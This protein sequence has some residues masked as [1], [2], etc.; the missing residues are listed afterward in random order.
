VTNYL[1]GL[2]TLLQV[3]FTTTAD[4]LGRATGFIQRQRRLRAAAFAQT[5]VFRWMAKPT[6]TL[7]AL[8]RQLQLSPQALHQRLGPRAQS[9]LRALL[10]EALRAALKVPPQRLGL[11]D[12]FTAV[13][14]EDTT[15][16]ALPAALADEF[17][18]CGGGT[19]AGEGAAALKVLVRWDVRSGAVLALTV[20]AGR[21]SDQELAA[22][23]AD[24]P[25]GALHLADQGFFNSRRWQAFSPRQFWISRVPTRTGVRWR[26]AWQTLSTLLAGVAG[27]QFDE[28]VHL[29]EQTALPC[30]LV[31]RRCPAEVANRRRQKLRESL[32][33]KK[34]RAPSAAQLLLCEWLVFATNTTAAQLGAQEVWVAYR[35]RWQVELLFKRAKQLAGWGSSRGRTGAR[36]LVELYAKLLGLVVLHWGTLLGGGPLNG[37][38]LWKRLCEVQE[39]ARSL[40]DS[41]AEGL[42]AVCRVLAKLT[43]QLASIPP[44]PKSRTRPSTRQLL[45]KPELAR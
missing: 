40:Q 22:T 4:R 2:A 11:L 28:A 12:R 26:G 7:E 13:V 3:L 41:L 31:A 37:I 17:P 16:I 8:A 24:L 27:D 44:E 19:G 29:V 35:C 15:V 10:V 20:H 45:L 14:L 6:T 21:T 25:D 5:L 34:G 18:G 43:Q 9:F 36:V 33:R 39:C 38:S 30:R 1:T 32:R 42:P 23:A